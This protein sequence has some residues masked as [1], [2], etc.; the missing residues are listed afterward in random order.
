MTVTV[1]NLITAKF[2]ESSQTTQ[3]TSSDGKTI[4]D[5][6]TATNTGTED[7]DFSVNLVPSTGSVSGSNLILDA[8]TIAPGETY[9]CGELIAQVLENGDQISTLSTLPDVLT[10]KASGRII[11]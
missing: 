5:K 10:I 2:A 4:I 6:F 8:R 1:S 7:V 11:T 3:Y 9:L